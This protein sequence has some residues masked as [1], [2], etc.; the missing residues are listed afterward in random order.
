MRLLFGILQHVL[1]ADALEKSQNTFV[2]TLQGTPDSTA[3]QMAAGR[4]CRE[5]V[6]QDNGPIDRPN[7]FKRGDQPRVA[8]QAVATICSV[9]GNE[10]SGLPEPLQ[11]LR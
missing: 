1:D 7:H 10:K 4:V 9:F 3:A 8:R 11:E 6:R 5:A 2:Y